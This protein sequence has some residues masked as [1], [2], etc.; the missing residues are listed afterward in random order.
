M[1]TSCVGFF[2]EGEAPNTPSWCWWLQGSDWW[3]HL[4]SAALKF[5]IYCV[6]ASSETTSFPA[7]SQGREG[8]VFPKRQSE[9][10]FVLSLQCLRSG[11]PCSNYHFT[12]IWGTRRAFQSF[13]EIQH[14]FRVTF[15]KNKSCCGRCVV[16]SWRGNYPLDVSDVL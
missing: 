7:Q 5:V 1:K 2:G 4:Y 8:F 6:W 9:K 15:V 14:Y 10:C 13:R 11:P 3:L 16:S 12:L